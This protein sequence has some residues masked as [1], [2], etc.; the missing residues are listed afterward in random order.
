MQNVRPFVTETDSKYLGNHILAGLQGRENGFM[1]DLRASCLNDPHQ[2]WAKLRKNS[3]SCLRCSRPGRVGS[4]SPPP[5]GLAAAAFSVDWVTSNFEGLV[6]S[7]SQSW[8]LR[9]LRG[10]CVEV[11]V[12]VA[13]VVT[14]ADLFF[15]TLHKLVTLVLWHRFL[16][17]NMCLINEAHCHQRAMT[18]FWIDPTIS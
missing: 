11:S 10:C 13:G 2:T 16:Y 12:A 8:Q 5:S 14:S 17:T 7:Q 4:N 15:F 18:L 9:G 1:A 3:W 6:L